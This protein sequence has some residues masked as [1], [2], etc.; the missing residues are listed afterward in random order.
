MKN[1]YGFSIVFFLA[2]CLLISCDQEHENKGAVSDHGEK[3]SIYTIVP[4]DISTFL[5]GSGTDSFLISAHRGSRYYKGWPENCLESFE[6]ILTQVP[7]LIEFDIRLS[8][9]SVLF[10]LHD[11]T[12]DR[13]TTGSGRADSFYFQEINSLNLLDSEGHL[14]DYH[15]SKLSD[16]LKWGKG[17]TILKLDIKQNVPYGRVIEEIREAEA[18]DH[19]M[20]IV[21]S[22]RAAEAF[23]RQ[24]DDIMMSVPVR[25]MNEFQRLLDSELPLDRVVAF[26]GTRK[27]DTALFDA[28]R[29]KN[30]ISIQGTIGNL[31]QQ[32]LNKG[33]DFL[34]KW[35]EEGADILATD[36]PI[37]LY[38]FIKS[39]K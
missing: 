30:I 28:L 21:Y 26:T 38:N 18:E 32:A 35:Y 23:H 37:E 16:V 9:D 7:A 17:R 25:N 3:D 15:P 1:F 2:L 29:Q 39:L 4:E 8:K 5:S 12:L 24:A 34:T 36:Y 31:D 10:L 33:F 14:T 6:Y 20:V 11:E 19:L 13:T 27:T 22:I